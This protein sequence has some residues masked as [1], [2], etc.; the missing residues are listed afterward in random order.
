[1]SQSIHSLLPKTL[2]VSV[3]GIMALQSASADSVPTTTLQTITVFAQPT[4]IVNQA[5]NDTI[6]TADSIPMQQADH[7]SGFL[8]QVP[9]VTVGGV[10]GMDQR[11]Y[12]RGQSDE[13][14]K[15]TIDGVRQENNF[16]YHAGRL[17]IDTDLLKAAEVSVGNNSVT[18][19][20]NATGGAVAFLTLDAK[21]LLKPNQTLGG[22]VKLEYHSNDKQ[23]HSVG[24]VYGAPNEKFDFLLSYGHRKSDGGEDGLGRHI[25]GDNIKI[26]NMLAKVNFYPAQNHQVIASFKRYDNEGNYPT[27]TEFPYYETKIN[28]EKYLVELKKYQDVLKTNP[29]AK[30]PASQ[31][32]ISPGYH[33]NDEF[34]LGYE[35]RPSDDFDVAVNAYHTDRDFKI[36]G[37][38]GSGG[39]TGI[40]V[41]T[42]QQINQE[43]IK[44]KLIYGG[45]FYRKHS[46]NEA[47]ATK[48]KQ[49]A[50]SYSAY[51]EDQIR[52]GRFQVTPGIRYD[53]YDPAS[54]VGN[55][56]FDQISGALAGSF[57]V[58]DNID[59]F[60]S[61]TQFFNGPPLPGTNFN[62]T[63][64]ENKK[65]NKTVAVV[66]NPDLKP[67]TGTNAEFGISTHAK[68]LI[69]D[70]DKATFVAKVFR[71]NF[72]DIVEFDDRTFRNCNTLAVEDTGACSIYVNLG[73][74]KVDGFEVATNYQ[75][76]NLALR[77][78]YSKS[79]S[80]VNHNKY[81]ELNLRDNSGTFNFGV[82]YDFNNGA[83]VGAAFKMVSSNDRREI[84][85]GTP[86]VFHYDSYNVFDIYGS[87]IPPSIPSLKLNLGVYNVADKAY[88]SHSSKISSDRGNDYEMGR[89]IKV[90]A[91]YR[92]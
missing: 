11:V 5:Q 22:Q 61:Y 55:K 24:T 60:A 85:R 51:V 12:I 9:G 58:N 86:K 37:I 47:S 45:E 21:D 67:E 7:L 35:Y 15:M 26:D 1:M 4:N 77:A 78:S 52:F 49:E 25:R 29:K 72:D 43:N 40:T 54:N 20:N 31:V 23:V 75:L 32:P 62:A 46:T 92:F 3:L 79:D 69:K 30:K 44:H 14:L 91:T 66:A 16:F 34:T 33:K 50:N 19:G 41:K 6:Y 80:K 83:T 8:S 82:D 57:A 88:Y 27:R 39:T 28:Y 76:N 65:I 84:D 10:S 64:R 68:G 73:K 56:T 36:G 90:G 38:L 89:N 59:V 81:G 63:G 87:Y 18:L 17:A 2:T 53:Y 70:N 42:H 13:R 71:T 48:A 74:T